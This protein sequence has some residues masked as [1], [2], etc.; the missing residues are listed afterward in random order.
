MK[1]PNKY[2]LRLAA[3]ALRWAAFGY[4]KPADQNAIGEVRLWLLHLAE[5]DDETR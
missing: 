2:A 4:R 1:R 3:M 5:Q